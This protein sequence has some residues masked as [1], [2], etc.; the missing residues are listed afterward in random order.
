ML[1]E[2]HVCGLMCADSSVLEPHTLSDRHVGLLGSLADLSSDIASALT[3]L[4]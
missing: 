1:G 4:L 3:A 2:Y